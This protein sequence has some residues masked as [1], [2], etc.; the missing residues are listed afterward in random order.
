MT[1]GSKLVQLRP[2]LSVSCVFWAIAVLCWLLKGNIF[3]LFNFGYIGTSVA[4][5]LGAC[6]LLPRKRKPAG[7]K[8]AQYLVGL[9]MLGFLGLVARENM[10]IEGF[11]F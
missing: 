9:Y 8:F 2:V 10:Q 4:V 11:F 7:R 5:G 6:S 3:F 1:Q